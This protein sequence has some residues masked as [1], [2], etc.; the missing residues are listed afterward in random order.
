MRAG[1]A[2]G[3]P[4]RAGA[5]TARPICD[6]S[7]DSCGHAAGNYRIVMNP[8]GKLLAAATDRDLPRLDDRFYLEVF[9][10]TQ[11]PKAAAAE[12]R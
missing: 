8:A 1:A 5:Q 2:D 9:A 12:K 4:L 11:R 7:K 3:H 6:R 10:Q